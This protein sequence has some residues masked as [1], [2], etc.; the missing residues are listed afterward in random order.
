MTKKFG[1]DFDP[2][3][4]VATGQT[5]LRRVVSICFDLAFP[6][7]LVAVAFAVGQYFSVI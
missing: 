1:Q 2:A 7:L 6:L 3:G 5:R 4:G